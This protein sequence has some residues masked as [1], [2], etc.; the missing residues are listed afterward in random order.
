MSAENKILEGKK[1]YNNGK[2][3]IAFDLYSEGL[4]MQWV[5]Q[6][7]LIGWLDVFKICFPEHG[8]EIDDEISPKFDDL[9]I[10]E[11]RPYKTKLEWN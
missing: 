3:Q 8:N 4:Q 6:I 9:Y 11:F 10:T 7:K 5:L 1:A 2:Y